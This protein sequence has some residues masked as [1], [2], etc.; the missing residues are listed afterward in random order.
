MREKYKT[1]ILFKSAYSSAAPGDFFKIQLSPL[2]QQIKSGTLLWGE[3]AHH[4]SHQPNT[5]HHSG[6]QVEIFNWKAC[7]RRA[8]EQTSFVLN[9]FLPACVSHVCFGDSG[10]DNKPKGSG[11]S[12]KE[13]TLPEGT[14]SHLPHAT[15]IQT[16]V[17]ILNHGN[18]S[19]PPSTHVHG[20]LRATLRAPASFCPAL[21]GM[22][23]YCST[24][25]RPQGTLTQPVYQS[26]KERD[27]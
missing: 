6:Q 18:Q 13:T 4:R 11:V 9:L 8:N 16:W 23:S 2:K 24:S 10:G 3:G 1:I 25:E 19:L 17:E 20:G 7:E 22:K 14:S 15:A 12:Q 5:E 26:D 21:D 27:K